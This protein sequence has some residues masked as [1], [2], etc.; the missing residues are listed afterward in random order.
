MG[1]I[2]VKVAP[3][4]LTSIVNIL[5]FVTDLFLFPVTNGCSAIGEKPIP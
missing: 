2:E 1:S 3:I 5:Q 4:G